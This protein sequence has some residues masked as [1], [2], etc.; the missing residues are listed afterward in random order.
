MPS[1]NDQVAQYLRDHVTINLPSQDPRARTSVSKRFTRV[2]S[3]LPDQ[4]LELF[5]SGRRPLS[6]AVMPTPGA[7]MTMRTES[8]GPVYAREYSIVLYEEHLSLPEDPFVGAVLRELG[9]VVGQIPPEEEW[10]PTRVDRAQFKERLEN[11]ADAMV[12][13][14]GLKRYSLAYLNTTF[15]PHWVERIV[16]DIERV[17]AERAGL[18]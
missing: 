6:I 9:H 1:K 11:L 3:L 13:R 15:P 4:A 8:S 2:F 12:W 14:W 10:P 7:P 5:L 16:G 17:V 18:H